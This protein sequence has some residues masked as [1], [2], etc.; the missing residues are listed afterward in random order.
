MELQVAQIFFAAHEI[1]CVHF[2]M[3]QA[4]NLWRGGSASG[5]LNFVSM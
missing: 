2:A 5:G 1:F 3:Q 4:I